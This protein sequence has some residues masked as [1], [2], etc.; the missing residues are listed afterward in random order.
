MSTWATIYNVAI[1]HGNAGFYPHLVHLSQSANVFTQL[2]F[3]QLPS[4]KRPQLGL[5]LSPSSLFSVDPALY[6][7]CA[8]DRR[9]SEGKDLC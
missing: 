2:C 3:D 5:D 9:Q 8:R 4:A 7:V 6:L 1:T